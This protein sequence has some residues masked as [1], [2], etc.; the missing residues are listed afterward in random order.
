MLRYKIIDYT[1]N[2]I[3]SVLA[4]FWVALVILLFA[5]L[6][7]PEFLNGVG[8]L[9]DLYHQ[10]FDTDIVLSITFFLIHFRL[11]LDCLR[12]VHIV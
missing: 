7:D 10:H 9:E 2:F 4:L 12:R 6:S 11:L 1:A 3:L 8:F 5:P